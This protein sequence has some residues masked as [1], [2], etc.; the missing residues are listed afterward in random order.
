MENIIKELHTTFKLPEESITE[1]KEGYYVSRA[2]MQKLFSCVS[3]ARRLNVTYRSS[4][5]S[6]GIDPWTDK[7]L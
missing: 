3:Y 2:A 5:G 7:E 6:F 1:A 4:L